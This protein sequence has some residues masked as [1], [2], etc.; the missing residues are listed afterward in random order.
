MENMNMENM[1]KEK[2]NLMTQAKGEAE[3]IRIQA[4]AIQS[5]GGKEYVNL[6]TIEKWDGR[7]PI[8]LYGSA[9][10]PFLNVAN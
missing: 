5:Q 2:I 9:P 1:G 4:Q 3:A 10:I 8:N 6:K 7:L